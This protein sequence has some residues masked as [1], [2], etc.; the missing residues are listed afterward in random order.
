[1]SHD[2]FRTLGRGKENVVNKKAKGKGDISV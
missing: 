2:D 1:M